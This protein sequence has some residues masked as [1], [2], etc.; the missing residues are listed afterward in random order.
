ML[1]GGGDTKVFGVALTQEIEV[2]ASP[3][4]TDRGVAQTCPTLYEGKAK[5]FTLSLGG[6]KKFGTHDFSI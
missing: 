3:L 6:P 5:G 1:K 4:Q 2:L